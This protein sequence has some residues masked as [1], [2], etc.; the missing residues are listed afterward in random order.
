MCLKDLVNELEPLNAQCKEMRVQF[1]F[2]MN[3]LNGIQRSNWHGG[4]Q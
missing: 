1:G 2:M 3:D 4:V